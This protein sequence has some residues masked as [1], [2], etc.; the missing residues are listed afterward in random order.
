MKMLGIVLE[1]RVIRNA[2][3]L[4]MDSFPS[5]CN[6]MFLIKF[7][8]GLCII[9]GLASQSKSIKCFIDKKTKDSEPDMSFLPGFCFD[10]IGHYS[11]SLYSWL[12]GV[13]TKYTT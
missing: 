2:Y 4:D 11:L 1:E 13:D 7:F 5:V 3:Q 9:L 10:L 8:I 12:L 6:K